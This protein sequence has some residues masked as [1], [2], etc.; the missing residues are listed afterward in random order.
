MCSS[1][2]ILSVFV[3]LAMCST[4]AAMRLGPLRSAFSNIATRS[5][6]VLHPFNTFAPTVSEKQSPARMILKSYLG[7]NFKVDKS[8][9]SFN[10]QN[11]ILRA[12]KAAVGDSLQVAGGYYR[13]VNQGLLDNDDAVSDFLVQWMQKYPNAVQFGMV[14]YTAY[15]VYRYVFN[16]TMIFYSCQRSVTDFIYCFVLTIFRND[17]RKY[18]LIPYRRIAQDLLWLLKRRSK[19]RR[20]KYRN[21]I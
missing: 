20:C 3:L 16:T 21:S 2:T 1:K 11:E 9:R 14:A 8:P 10:S 6:S 19:K 4:A 18:F 7:T 12:L 17:L 5:S 15:S 13:L